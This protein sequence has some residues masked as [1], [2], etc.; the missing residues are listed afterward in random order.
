VGVAPEA[1]SFHLVERGF[2]RFARGVRLPGACD[3]ARARAAL[4]AGELSLSVPR[5]AE[6]RGRQI[7]VPIER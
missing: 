2:G 1:A 3:A 6:R 4:R 7:M 5:I